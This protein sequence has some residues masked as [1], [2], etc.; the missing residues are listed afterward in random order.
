MKIPAG[1][2][3]DK[4][5]LR[6]L[7]TG[8]EDAQ[9]SYGRCLSGGD[10]NCRVAVFVH[11]GCEA[12]DGVRVAYIPDFHILRKTAQADCERPQKRFFRE[13]IQ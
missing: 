3:S 6:N 7:R 1:D 4:F 10:D 8:R 9:T 5:R 13:Y 2:L 11:I 12:A